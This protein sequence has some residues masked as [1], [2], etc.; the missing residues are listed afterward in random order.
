MKTLK[1]TGFNALLLSAIAGCGSDGFATA[2]TS[3][4]VVCEGIPVANAMVYFEPLPSGAG[5]N[6]NAIVGKQG[7]SFTDSE[8]KFVISTYDPGRGDGAVI[9]RHRVRVGRGDAKCDCVTND[10]RTL[11]E[12]DIKPDVNNEFEIVLPKATAQDRVLEK[13]QNPFGDD[14]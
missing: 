1:I 3:G 7:F 13:T 11:I 6:N 5:G 2:P 10:E 9:G 8:G 12:V 4:R 14:E